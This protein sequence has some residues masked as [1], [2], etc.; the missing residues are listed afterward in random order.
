MILTVIIRDEG[1]VMHLNEPVAYRSVQIIL[2]PEQ[3]R[4][5][6]LRHKNE[7]VSSCFL[8]PPLGGEIEEIDI[9]LKPGQEHSYSAPLNGRDGHFKMKGS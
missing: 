3:A 4:I 6:R 1:P 9:K 8:E 5:V 7:A 2:T